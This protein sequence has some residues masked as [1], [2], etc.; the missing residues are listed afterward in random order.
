MTFTPFFLSAVSMYALVLNTHY[1]GLAIIQEL[2]RRGVDVRACDS[3][4]SVG[5]SSR[6]ARFS[7]CP[8]PRDDEAGLVSFLVEYGKRQGARGVLFP[9]ND[10]WAIA[11]ARGRESLAPYFEICAPPIDVISLV[12]DKLGFARWA[13]SHGLPV[14]KSWTFDEVNAIPDSDFPVVCKPV[15]RRPTVADGNVV[16]THAFLDAHRFMVCHDR[17]SLELVASRIHDWKSSF[18]IQQCVEGLSDQMFTVGVYVD[19]SSRVRVIFTGR[20][21]RGFPPDYGDCVV[22]QSEHAPQ[23]LIEMVH[24]TCRDLGISGIAEFEFKRDVRTGEFFLIEINPRSW[25]W[26]GIT[27]ACAASIPWF[28]F[29]DMAGGIIPPLV[30]SHAADGEVKWVKVLEDFMN[31]LVRNKRLGFSAWS[32]SLWQWR[33]TLRCRTLVTAE[34]SRDDLGPTLYAARELMASFVA[35]LGRRCRLRRRKQGTT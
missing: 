19:K 11:V 2:G 24:A 17:Q 29:Q 28:A 5:A 32:Y 23:T 25:S 15:Y 26:I 12:L 27:P 35:A 16:A 13:T 7:L 4:H 31:C 9:T 6:Y 10:N 30:E 14:P 1:N 21:V 18:M 3:R 20:K 22:G 33:N 8:D 34:F